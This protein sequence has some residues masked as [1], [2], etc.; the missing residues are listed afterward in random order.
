MWDDPRE[1]QILKG[2][3]MKDT[4]QPA[5]LPNRILDLGI[6]IDDLDNIH[7]LE[8]PAEAEKALYAALSHC[9]LREDIETTKTISHNI[10][11]RLT[12]LPL[13]DLPDSFSQ[14]I[15]VCQR[16]GVQYLWIDSLCIIQDDS[17]DWKREA[18]DMNNI[19]A[20]AWFTIAMHHSTRGYIPFK[21]IQLTV[22]RQSAAV[23]VRR[24][25]ELLDIVTNRAIAPAVR[26]VYEV[27]ENEH[28]NSV[29]QRGWCYQERALSH[30]MVHF[31]DH[32][33]LYEERGT[34]KRC[35]CNWHFGFGTG[36]AGSQLGGTHH[37]WRTL[38]QQY[39]QRM[40]GRRSDLLPGFAGVAERFSQR[41]D[42]GLYVAGL[43]E[44]DLIK[45]LCWRS[46]EWVSA[47]ASTWACE[48]CRPH[49]QRI[50]WTSDEPIPSFSWASRFGPCEFVYESWKLSDSIEVASIERVEC[51]MDEESPFLK[52]RRLVPKNWP[53]D[54]C[55][56]YLRIRG[57][58]YPC[59]H[60]STSG[61][62][63]AFKRSM[64]LCDKEYAWAVP[65]HYVGEWDL[66]QDATLILNDARKYGKGYCIDAGDDL[67]P[68]NS[69]IYLLPLFEYPDS[70]AKTCLI[71]RQCSEKITAEVL[72]T[73]R[74]SE[75]LHWMERIGI[76]V[77]NHSWFGTIKEMPNQAIHLM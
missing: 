13:S 61:K 29:T 52:V 11:T 77:L 62:G 37:A 5:K 73:V 7:I 22:G 18:A 24:I 10:T 49:P 19:Y 40:F 68:D 25:P 15:S 76:A 64:F 33:Y 46:Q 67:P 59:K 69:R 51:L 53:E 72:D 60:F 54:P 39:T 2:W 9:W 50:P 48:D 35:Q 55:G 30:R 31:T 75:S 41:G 63:F 66:S 32:E 12:S 6:G 1:I 21:N 70:Q 17:A 20:N 14:A 4:P 34:L 8:R 36:F 44:K 58:L 3:L 16:I 28:W 26:N 47:R 23:H 74:D 38:V 27:A 43:W 65:D 57:S 45:W 56:R 42:L 71:L